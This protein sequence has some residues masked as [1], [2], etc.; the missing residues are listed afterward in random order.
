MEGKITWERGNTWRKAYDSIQWFP[1]TFGCSKNWYLCRKTMFTCWISLFCNGF[2]LEPTAQ[3]TLVYTKKYLKA[4]E[5]LWKLKYFTI[6][7]K[8]IISK[9][10][11]KETK[12]LQDV[13]KYSKG[14]CDRS[15]WSFF[16]PSMDEII[17]GR[18]PWHK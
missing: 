3:A 8:N 14:R 5:E 7:C 6:W 2:T 1:F 10:P 16:H 12:T 11:L 15:S 18:K 9:N 4:K 17:Q 13:I